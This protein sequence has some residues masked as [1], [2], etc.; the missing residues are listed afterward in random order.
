MC[1]DNLKILQTY[2]NNIK[3]FRQIQKQHSLTTMLQLHKVLSIKCRCF[4]KNIL[5]IINAKANTLHRLRQILRCKNYY[6]TLLQVV[7]VK[8]WELLPEPPEKILLQI[9]IARMNLYKKPENPQINMAV[10]GLCG[11]A[12]NRSAELQKARYNIL[13]DMQQIL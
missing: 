12:L 9:W 2:K 7:Q 5:I 11:K 10:Q 3:N 4:Y 13:Q 8:I 1:Y 6:I